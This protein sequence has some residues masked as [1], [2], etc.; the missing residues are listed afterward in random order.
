MNTENNISLKIDNIK[1]KD[2]GLLSPCGILCL[3][4]DTHLGEGLGAAKKLKEIWEGWNLMDV[5]PVLGL[6]PKDVKATFKTLNFYLKSADKQG[7]CPGCHKAGNKIC[8]IANCVRSKDFWT[9][10]ECDDYNPESE[11]P[12]PHG[13]PSPMLMGDSKEWMKMICTRYS[14]DTNN[15]LKRCREIGYDA[16]IKEAKEKVANGWRTWQ[17]ISDEMVFTKAMK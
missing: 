14:K 2:N 3:G 5:A 7:I 17:V 15:N 16:F 6:N 4:C 12:C 9:C 13:T 10:A 1:D 8:G 11:T